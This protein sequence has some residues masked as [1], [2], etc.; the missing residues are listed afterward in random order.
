MQTIDNNWEN[1]L[2]AQNPAQST[3][4]DPLNVIEQLTWSD[5]SI[6]LLLV[7]FTITGLKRGFA[8]GLINFI[9]IIAAFIVASVFYQMLN[10]SGFWLFKNQ[11]LI[12]FCVLFVAFLLLKIGLYK[13]LASIA[14][15]HGSCPL[16]R[17]LA[18]VISVAIA[19]G[20]S[21]VLA[22]NIAHIELIVR[23]ITHEEFRT[24]AS[25]IL[26]FGAIII[27]AF[28][29]IKMLNIK[30]GT[31]QPC[32]LLLALRPLDSILSAKNINSPINHFFGLWLGLFKGAVFIV[33]VIV[34]L[35][36]IDTSINGILTDEFNTI[37][38]NTQTVLSDYLTFIEK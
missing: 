7:L 1:T 9:W 12:S 11:A 16:N 10:E 15:I 13:I 23:L 32:P 35:N 31:D 8:L 21:W 36:H 3:W 5:Y 17:F 38:T 33:L 22:H 2:G 37:A 27:S 18:I 34:V 25:L 30:V 29:L 24:I 20:I 14:K 4:T 28:V 6:F 19:F 26:I